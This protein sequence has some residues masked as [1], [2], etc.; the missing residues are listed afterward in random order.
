MRLVRLYYFIPLAWRAYISGLSNAK[1]AAPK[2]HSYLWPAGLK[3][4]WA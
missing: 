3:Y 2:K 1:S 4:L